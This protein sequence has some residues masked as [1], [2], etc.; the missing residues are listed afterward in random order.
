[1]D[2]RNAE[3][4]GAPHHVQGDPKAAEEAA[5]VEAAV[6]A[7]DAAE[8]EVAEA[9]VVP[10]AP[11]PRPVL[12]AGEY[13]TATLNLFHNAI[14]HLARAMDPVYGAME[15]GLGTDGIEAVA[16]D[17]EG[18]S[19]ESPMVNVSYAIDIDPEDVRHVRLGEFHVAALEAATS[20][21]E[22]VA[23]SYQDYLDAA[24]AAV[25]NHRTIPKGAFNWDT[26]LDL[27]EQV[28]WTEGADGMVHPPRAVVGSALPELGEKT[29][30]QVF[31]EALINHSKQEEHVARRRRRRLR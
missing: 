3:P 10:A 21:L 22:Q 9:D 23:Q 17:V 25:G 13:S 11:G 7:A 29:P 14:E 28:E 30:Q 5:A 24:T 20:R 8:V 18:V 6:E 1:M 27:L 2:G 4:L 15:S 26:V 31:R 12:A 19:V 16:V